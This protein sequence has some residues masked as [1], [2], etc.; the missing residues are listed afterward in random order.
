MLDE[1]LDSLIGEYE[2]R[3]STENIWPNLVIRVSK[4]SKKAET[5]VEY[6]CFADEGL[7]VDKI[8]KLIEEVNA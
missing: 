4:G 2:V 8:K 1:F 7:I 3:F 6:M 5:M